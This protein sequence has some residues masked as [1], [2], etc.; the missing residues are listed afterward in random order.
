MSLIKLQVHSLHVGKGHL[1]MT[2]PCQQ[3]QWLHVYINYKEFA[4]LQ[5]SAHTILQM[6][7]AKSEEP[8][9]GLL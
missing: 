3:Q 1:L 9:A 7:T 8:S 5:G 4:S 6:V 2:E